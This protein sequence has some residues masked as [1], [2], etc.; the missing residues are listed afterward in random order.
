MFV[1]LV[2]RT[3]KQFDEFQTLIPDLLK[4]LPYLALSI[5]KMKQY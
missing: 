3:N 5:A 2:L 1:L 4:Y